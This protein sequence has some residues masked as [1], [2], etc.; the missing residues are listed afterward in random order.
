MLVFYRFII[1][2]RIFFWYLF[3]IRR[4]EFIFVWVLLGCSLLSAL[5]FYMISLSFIGFCLFIGMAAGVLVLVSYCVAIGSFIN[6]SGKVNKKNLFEISDFGG[7]IKKII[8]ISLI[9]VL[10]KRYS[11]F[12]FLAGSNVSPFTWLLF[13]TRGVI[14]GF[15]TIAFGFR[16]ER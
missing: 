14:E 4:K 2:I 12:S 6:F 9:K 13:F 15:F 8:K 16:N 3:Y 10:I 7:M 5:L 11:S 1:F